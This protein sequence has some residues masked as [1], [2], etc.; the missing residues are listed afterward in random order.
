M[1]GIRSWQ[2]R[3]ETIR[4][5]SDSQEKTGPRLTLKIQP[6][7]R[8]INYCVRWDSSSTVTKDQRDQINS[9]LATQYAK[10]FSWTAGYDNFPYANISV[11]VV[12]WATR[13]PSLL[14]GDTS[15]IEVY[16]DADV[17][18]VPECAQACGRAFHQDGDFSGCSAGEAGR[19]DQSLWLTD[20]FEGGTGGDWG[21][22]VGTDY[23]LGAL[24]T[25]N[26]HI[27]LHEMVSLARFP[28]FRTIWN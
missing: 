18:G 3:G 21:Q 5:I 22:R 25:E 4:S 20:G 24:G 17:D 12:G 9:A 10:W 11:N 6:P 1:G 27:L 16:T 2:P 15:D 13:D 8:S 26:I 23:M 14:E 28:L 19:Y 7:N